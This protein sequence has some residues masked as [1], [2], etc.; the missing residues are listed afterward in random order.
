MGK[1]GDYLEECQLTGG[2]GLAC[3]QGAA[4]V[5]VVC[6]LCPALV[7]FLP[8]LVNALQPWHS[9]WG[10]CGWPFPVSWCSCRIFMTH[11]IS[12]IIGFSTCLNSVSMPLSLTPVSLQNIMCSPHIRGGC[13]PARCGPPAAQ[14]RPPPCLPSLCPASSPRILGSLL[15][16]VCWLRRWRLRSRWGCC[17]SW[18]RWARL[19]SPLCSPRGVE[20]WS[21]GATQCTKRR[22][23]ACP[24]AWPNGC[25]MTCRSRCRAS[26]SRP[27]LQV[28]GEVEAQ[29]MFLQQVHHGANGRGGGWSDHWQGRLGARVESGI[30]DS[31][32][33]AVAAK[34]RESARTPSSSSTCSFHLACWR[35][36]QGCKF[37]R[38]PSPLSAD[39][40]SFAM[41]SLMLS[42][43]ISND[44]VFAG[45]QL[46]DS[47]RKEQQLFM[48]GSFFRPGH[49]GST[50][51]G[52]L[53]R[54]EASRGTRG[55]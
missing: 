51:I 15:N 3:P 22:H 4:A 25:R 53:T 47:D 30:N 24:I 48:S 27:L 34:S 44:L 43:N 5:G 36:P 17:W 23:Y 39:C 20:S 35:Y 12:G 26:S 28:I 14:R 46:I 11:F 54:S 19:I 16:G 42:P 38:H 9:P 18:G 10:C 31:T 37:F 41:V 1:V 7:I 49:P 2:E 33:I 8:S 6:L 40:M 52:P 50:R 45:D 21:R 32:V 55:P 13:R 29:H